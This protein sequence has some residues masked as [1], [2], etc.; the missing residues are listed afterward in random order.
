MEWYQ[1]WDHPYVEILD[2]EAQRYLKKA[3]KESSK[4]KESM[5]EEDDWEKIV[6]ERVNWVV[7]DM[8][9]MID[10]GEKLTVPEQRLLR[11]R[12]KGIIIPE[13]TVLHA[14]EEERSR[15]GKRDRYPSSSDDSDTPSGEQAQSKQGKGGRGSRGGG[16]K[17]GRGR[18]EKGGRVGTSARGG[19]GGGKKTST[20][21]GRGKRGKKARVVEQVVEQEKE[22]DDL[23][24]F[25]EHIFGG[26]GIK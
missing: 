15:R 2:P 14:Y 18:G 10:L 22:D 12:V 3:E 11:N 7:K 17:G 20:Q 5:N 21:V 13:K 23:D 1:E 9:R 6:V 19:G 24:T 26:G 4:S 16:E 8:S 25:F